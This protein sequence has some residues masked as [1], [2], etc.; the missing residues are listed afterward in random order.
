MA[1]IL[2]Y[3]EVGPEYFG[4]ISARSIISKLESIPADDRVT[5]RINSPGGD[6]WEADA[7]YNAFARRPGGVV[8]EVD[9]IAASS[10]SYIAMAGK[11]IRIAENAKMMIHNPWAIVIGDA[12]ELRA[13]ADVL[14]EHTKP[15][16]KAY[17]ARSGQDQQLI[18]Q[19]MDDE[20]WMG[21]ETA[22]ELGFADAIGQP[23]NVKASIRPGQFPKQPADLLTDTGQLFRARA[24][25]RARH[26][27]FLKAKIRCSGSF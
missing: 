22:L 1:E 10:A 5:V 24:A 12:E 18:R 26:I 17:A 13:R 3:D 14:D 23:L 21:A 6:I 15:I 19:M 7:I 4:L 2:I 20:T 11:E 9:S 16:I 27:A 8:V 25:R